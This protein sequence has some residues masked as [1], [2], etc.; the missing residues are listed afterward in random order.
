M[1][2]AVRSGSTRFGGWSRARLTANGLWSMPNFEVARYRR[3]D[4]ESRGAT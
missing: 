4:A 1:E 3:T 2:D